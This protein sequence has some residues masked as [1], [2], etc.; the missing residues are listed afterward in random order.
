MALAI[1]LS[2]V[3]VN[4]DYQ[5]RIKLNEVE[6]Q[7][8]MDLISEGTEFPPIVVF[9][10]SEENYILASGFHRFD[11]NKRLELTEISAEIRT[12]NHIDILVEAIQSN[13]KHGI[14]LT[15]E[16]KWHSVTLILKDIEA[17]N[18]ADNHIANL[19][20]V[21]NH[22]VKKI[23]S[24]IFPGEVKRSSVTA[25]RDGKVIEIETENIGPKSETAF[26]PEA[27][28]R[29]LNSKVH[30]LIKVLILFKESHNLPE[31]EI[32]NE[33][34]EAIHEFVQWYCGKKGV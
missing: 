13:A 28:S 31:V 22:L 25:M 26:S 27:L 8:Y 9:K 2:A 6:V 20:G 32:P 4:K 21:S 7:N 16:D 1:K 3:V 12:G 14:R 18:W 24:E 10:K 34:D 23:R 29:K 5:P 15:N 33:F 11:A 17:K 19:C 30:D